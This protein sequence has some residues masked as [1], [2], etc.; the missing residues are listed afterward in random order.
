MPARPSLVEHHLVGRAYPE[1]WGRAVLRKKPPGLLH[2]S[3]H[4]LPTPFCELSFLRPDTHRQTLNQRNGELSQLLE[5]ASVGVS[6][7]EGFLE[8]D[9]AEHKEYDVPG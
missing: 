3:S 7:K 4:P 8:E 2:M 5:R 9:K 1:S 6:V